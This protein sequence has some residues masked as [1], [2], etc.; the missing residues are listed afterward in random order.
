MKS[1]GGHGHHYGGMGS[2]YG[3][4][5]VNFGMRPEQKLRETCARHNIEVKYDE[6]SG[7]NN[8]SEYLSRV[9]VGSNP[10]HTLHGSGPTPEAARDA[11]AITAL[12]ILVET[13]MIKDEML[14]SA[15]GDGC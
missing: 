5:K 1:H 8:L 10:P 4:P 2:G 3:A 14:M 15:A 13:G 6:F 12:K 11:A 7:S 9:M